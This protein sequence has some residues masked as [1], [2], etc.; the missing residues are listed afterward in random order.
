MVIKK[1]REKETFEKRWT[2]VKGY[3]AVGIAADRPVHTA[4]HAAVTVMA[5]P[6]FTRP[7]DTII[8]LRFTHTDVLRWQF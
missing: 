4:N 1:D 7:I 5:E 3:R 2:V 8:G 6:A